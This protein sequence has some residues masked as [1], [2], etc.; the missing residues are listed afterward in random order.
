MTAAAA[1]L[2]AGTVDV[3]RGAELHAADLDAGGAD[4]ARAP[5]RGV[6]ELDREMAAVEADADV[7]EQERPR[8]A[9]SDTFSARASSGAPIGSRRR[10]KNSSVS[11]VFSSEQSGSGSI[12]R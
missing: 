12:S 4:A 2:S 5:S 11:S 1:S 9:D 3:E 8:A 6:L 7:L 10:S